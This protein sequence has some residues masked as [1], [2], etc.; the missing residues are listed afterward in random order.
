VIIIQGLC[1]LIVESIKM[2]W[3]KI[4]KDTATATRSADLWVMNTEELYFPIVQLIKLK[5]K[6]YLEFNWTKQDVIDDILNTIAKEL[7]E[8]MTQSKGF[9]DE[10][11]SPVND[12]DEVGD[13]I[14]DVDWLEVAENFR[15]D[16]EEAMELYPEEELWK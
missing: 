8:M 15:E 12:R 9:M 5:V 16:I 6:G 13:S 10:L 2:S 3:K 14:S 4:L 11:L 1:V 7:P